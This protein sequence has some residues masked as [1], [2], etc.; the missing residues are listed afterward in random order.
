VP[1][2]KLATL[3]EC[4]GGKLVRGDLDATAT[5]FGIDTRRLQDGSAFFA[6][7]G[8]RTDGHKFV[9]QATRAGAVVAV[10]QDEIPEGAAAPPSVIRVGDVRQA[11]SRCGRWV[12]KAHDE[13]KWI[14]I[15]GSNG[16]TTAKELAAAG[17]GARY[18]VHR[19]PGNYNND[20]GVPLTLLAMP[21]GTEVAVV[22]TATS[23]PGEIASLTRLIDP[24]VGLVTN[25]RAVHMDSFQSIEDVAAAKGELFALMRDDATAVVNLDD[26]NVRVQATRHIGPQVTYGQHAS[27][28]LH[29]E[30]VEDR[31]LPGAGLTFRYNDETIR[32]QLRIGG[33]H[34]AHNAL[35]ALAVVAASGEDVRAAAEQ[36][37]QVEAGQ[38]RGKIHRLRRGIMVVD[39]SYN[40]SPP[41]LAS[42]LETLRLS[43]P[44]G[45]RVLVMGDM[46]EL[47]PMKTALHREAGRRAGA[48]GVQMLMSVGAMAKET[49][50]AARKKGVGEVHYYGDSAT[51]AKSIGDFLSDGDLIVVKG[52]RDVRM[53]RVVRALLEQFGEER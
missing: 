48:A 23:G 20:L 34:A 45:R 50:E 43:D 42:V 39:D 11:L 33:A 4:T 41:A 22:E 9:E 49:A 14:S 18:R 53:G 17:M 26:V 2:L 35:A 46:L 40:S 6:L 15:T 31:F 7:K 1:A 47:G 19:T 37:E 24:D 16:K 27:A 30:Q 29:L 52:S 8:E 3:V 28:D 25:I 32:V 5:S 12:R 51:C 36:M 13:V 10:V 44:R 21:A 38:G